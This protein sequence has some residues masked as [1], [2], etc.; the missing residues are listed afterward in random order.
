MDREA[1]IS[2]VDGNCLVFKEKFS[3]KL[4][5]YKLKKMTTI[6]RYFY[7]FVESVHG[8]A[9]PCND[10]VK[11]ASSFN[12]LAVKEHISRKHLHHV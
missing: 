6:F 5:T 10:K 2:G 7:K 4:L 3:A 1:G 11:V 12:D 9:L 8:F